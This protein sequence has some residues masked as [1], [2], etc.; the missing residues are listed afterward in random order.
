M[1][2][3]LRAL[4]CSL[5][6]LSI[7]AGAQSAS[8]AA[9]PKLLDDRLQLDIVAEEPR[10]V[11]PT[12][13]ACDE[14]GR[15]F[16]IES[17][18]H[19][20]PKDYDGPKGDRIRLFEDADGDGKFEKES[21]FAEGFMHAMGV[22]L[23][24]PR[25]LYVISR[26][27]LELLEDTDDDGK[28]DKQSTI[29]KLETKGNYPHNGLSG[30]TF[31]PL[32]NL[33]FS[34]GENLGEPYAIVGT[35][36]TRLTGGG[37]GGNIYRCRPDGSKLVKVA[38]GFW[39]TFGLG[40]DAFGNL[41]AVD[42]DPDSRPPCRLL[43]IVEGGDYGYRFRNGRKG[44]HPFTAWNG[45][46]P[47]T[48][49]MV[50]GT[51]EAPSGVQAYES[52]GLPADYLGKLFVTS[53][54]DYRLDVVTPKPRGA[55]F[56]GTLKTVVQ[57]GDDFRPVCL[58]V[59]PDG[60][61]YFTDWVKKDYT[62]HKRGKVWRLSTKDRK[63]SVAK[64]KPS[65]LANIDELA[66]RKLLLSPRAEIRWAAADRLAKLD[67][68]PQ[69]S[70][71]LGA[72]SGANETVQRAVFDLMAASVRAGKKPEVSLSN[73]SDPVAAAAVR[74]KLSE[75]DKEAP[76]VAIR[77]K[78][79]ILAMMENAGPG[80]FQAMVRDFTARQVDPF[81]DPEIDPF[82]ISGMVAYL[83]RTGTPEEVAALQTQESA[84]G[85][86]LGMLVLR[87]RS[88]K[89]DPAV[90]AKLLADPDARIRRAAIQWT[91]EA[92]VKELA[93][94][95]DA[96]VKQAPTPETFQAYLAAREALSGKRVSKDELSGQ[97][98]ALNLFLDPAVDPVLKRMA[99]KSISSAEPAL[100]AGELTKLLKSTDLATAREA[101]WILRDAPRKEAVAALSAV[102]S[103]NAVD[104]QLR[105]D[106]LEAL[107][108]SAAA[109]D[110]DAQKLL[111]TVQAT[112]D[113]PLQQAA[114]R[115]LRPVPVSSPDKPGG[116]LPTEK[117]AAVKAAFEKPGDAEN[118]R[119]IF[120]QARGIGCA[121]CHRVDGRGG[122]IGPDLSKVAGQLTDQRLI[123][124]LVTPSKEVAPQF[125]LWQ[126]TS[127]SGKVYSGVMLEKTPSQ[128][129]LADAAGQRH[130]ITVE[131]IDEQ[132]SSPKSLM[133]DGLLAPL[134]DDEIR[135]LAA[136]LRT[137][138]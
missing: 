82:L 85:R 14:R 22:A 137:L 3:L 106:A 57:G 19:F 49:P 107:A 67:A 43:H 26:Q 10:I 111:D 113:H 98:Y 138:K 27:Q 20:P 123:D 55:S 81:L 39:N 66:A 83:A 16:V 101:T 115:L 51:G 15:L 96:S 131:E 13:I 29:I 9:P 112:A 116:A 135:D 8:P 91:A 122:N 133:P 105:A 35:D 87:A 80:L 119:R 33:V 12:G 104:A 95:L 103:D 42:N 124:S 2:P 94:A 37:E 127:T 7:V 79:H 23:D 6:T 120:F 59:G 56:G 60:S 88:E 136:F 108:A 76:L 63:P 93:S 100:K 11:T 5:L 21:N 97:L 44:V 125:V 30:I 48:L 109:K 90:L 34:L 46:L 86:L 50:C 53:W 64:E 18:T 74:W 92:G 121:V 126:I 17:H 4:A 68:A 130:V 117:L 132:Q 99:L 45:E 69:L 65:D 1:S 114:V 89:P 110:A 54:G 129:T 24:G 58:A 28:A 71:K 77:G 73:L 25:K 70:A 75:V 36:G 38:T 32:G 61:L 40:Y 128:V 41:F 52:S 72:L 62:L 134:P 102:V 78:F 31:D 118:G 84:A 47:G